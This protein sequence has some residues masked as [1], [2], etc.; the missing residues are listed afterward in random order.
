MCLLLNQIFSLNSN[1]KIM[2]TFVV[3]SNLNVTISIIKNA[4]EDMKFVRAIAIN[5]N[6]CFCPLVNICNIAIN[7]YSL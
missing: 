2:A 3:K 5:M 1:I 6:I 4:P 7:F